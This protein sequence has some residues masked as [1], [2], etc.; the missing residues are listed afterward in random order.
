MHRRAAATLLIGSLMFVAAAFF[1]ISQEVFGNLD[2]PSAMAAS[3]AGGRAAW[4][5]ATVIF[6][7]GALVAA[8]GIWTLARQLEHTA[9]SAIGYI[10]GVAAVVAAVV[11][12]YVASLRVI[13]TPEEVAAALNGSDWTLLVGSLTAQI[14][15]IAI[16]YLLIR[17]SRDRLGWML[18]VVGV[19]TMTGYV[20]LGDMPP[21]VYYAAWL[22]AAITLLVSRRTPVDTA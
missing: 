17:S 15:L 4:I 2:D 16:G 10:G 12:A 13:D 7:V 21:G 11:Y 20:A 1:P 6:G 14:A 8:A 9:N 5:T 22:I 3:I 19:G 18:V